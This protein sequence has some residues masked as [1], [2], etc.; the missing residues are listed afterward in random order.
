MVS[1]TDVFFLFHGAGP[2]VLAQFLF[3]PWAGVSV[4]L[5]IIHAKRNKAAAVDASAKTRRVLN[6]FVS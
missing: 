5:A 2:S 6:G 3:T 4:D 1:G